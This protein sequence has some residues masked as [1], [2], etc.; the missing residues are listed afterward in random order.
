MALSQ[1]R[2]V[3]GTGG[4]P[5]A[6]CVVLNRLRCRFICIQHFDRPSTCMLARRARLISGCRIAPRSPR[7]TV[8]RLTQSSGVGAV[9]PIFGAI[10]SIGAIDSSAPH[11]RSSRRC[12]H[13]GR[14]AR[15]RTSGE[16]QPAFSFL[17]R[18]FREAE[19]HEISCGSGRRLPF[20]GK[21]AIDTTVGLK[22]LHGQKILDAPCHIHRHGTTNVTP[23][24]PSF[25]SRFVVALAWEKPFDHPVDGL[26]EVSMATGHS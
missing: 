11:R 20:R 24:E 2:H 18:C 16:I 25:I 17:T 26:G 9:R 14:S 13:T 10:D 19:S 21:A 6:V 23:V 22:G 12:S 7:L 3:S 8:S 5:P 4:L 1:C 15:S